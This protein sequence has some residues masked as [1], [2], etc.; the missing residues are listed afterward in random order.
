MVRIAEAGDCL[1]NIFTG[2]RKTAKL[3]S[4]NGTAIVKEEFPLF[5]DAPTITEWDRFEYEVIE[6]E[7]RE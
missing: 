7:K 5:D 4:D 2:E 3:V 1:R 6:K